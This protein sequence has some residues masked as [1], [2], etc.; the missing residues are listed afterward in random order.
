MS[1][2]QKMRRRLFRPR[3]VIEGYEN[4]ELVE[5]IYRKTVAFQAE[6]NWPLENVESVLDFGGGAGIHYKAARR[7]SPDVR[8]AVVETPAMV[9]RAKDLA[10]DR[11][12]FLS[13]SSRRPIGW[14]A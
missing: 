4:V 10:T 9:R 1:L 13:G 7:Q 14:E 5:T 12:M 6:G 2:I 8:W 3:E 11:L